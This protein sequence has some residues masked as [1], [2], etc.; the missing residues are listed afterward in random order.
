MLEL[1]FQGFI[2]WIYGLILECWEYFASVLFD[3]MSLDFAYL[4]EHIGA[5]MDAVQLDGVD[6]RGYLM[7]GPIDLVSATTGE[8]RKRYGFI[9]VD[10]QDDGSGT[11]ARSRKDS[12]YWFREVT[13][14]NGGTI[15]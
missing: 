5:V 2:E 12:F 7:W 15:R 3:L 13:E 4:R 1:L 9:Y 8:M 14:S 11:Y 6:C 10:K